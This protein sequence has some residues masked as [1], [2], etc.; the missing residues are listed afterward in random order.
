MR[1]Y[2]LQLIG[3]M[4]VVENSLINSDESIS[5]AAHREAERIE[6]PSLLP[7][8]IEYLS[9]CSSKKERDAA[10]FI[11][12]KLGR[13]VLSSECASFLLTRL[14]CETDKYVVAAMLDRLS[15][16]PKPSE[17]DLTPVFDLL[18][19]KRWL[20]RHSA[21]KAL[22]NTSSSE[23]E[24]RLI[25]HLSTTVD[26]DDQVYC[27]ATLNGIG[28]PRSIPMIRKGLESK[29]R[30]VKLSAELAIEA[31]NQRHATIQ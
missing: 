29:K 8:L 2:L 19:D 9:Q 11:V 22:N 23:A 28:T 27:N 3:R 5:F 16:I 20:V 21:I 30:D 17:M 13:N 1:D 31:I 25:D 4:T 12:G 10:Y 6:D 7:E 26:P 15:E 24:K 14:A 18:Q